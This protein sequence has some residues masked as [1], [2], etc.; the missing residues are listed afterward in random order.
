MSS[1][2]V[3]PDLFSDEAA[4]DRLLASLREQGA[5]LESGQQDVTSQL[6]LMHDYG[7]TGWGIPPE[8]GG[9]G[10]EGADIIAGYRKLSPAC[11]TSTFV[12]TQRQ[13]AISRIV[14]SENAELKSDLLPKL[15]ANEIFATV[16]ISHLTTSRQDLGQ[17][18]GE[19]N[20]VDGG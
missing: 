4:F 19:A 11:L 5:E 2:P 1:D 20:E 3:K 13:A 12:F 17:P 16:G 6:A 15:A 9:S 8:F 18:A 7:V 10:V 14:A